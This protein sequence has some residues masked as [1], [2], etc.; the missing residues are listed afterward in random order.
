MWQH[1]G[2]YPQT[3]LVNGLAD[4]TEKPK[5]KYQLYAR[6]CVCWNECVDEF[7]TCQQRNRTVFKEAVRCERHISNEK[8]KGGVQANETS[9]K[10]AENM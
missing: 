3:L 5:A 4:K 8:G 1:S 10:W 9:A 7:M 2:N 6:V